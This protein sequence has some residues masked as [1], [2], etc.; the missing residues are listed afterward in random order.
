MFRVMEM[1]RVWIIWGV[2]HTLGNICLSVSI[3][4]SRVLVVTLKSKTWG[5]FIK[6][7]MYLAVKFYFN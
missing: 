4:N 7:N 5:T 3:G 6:N 2:T 1:D